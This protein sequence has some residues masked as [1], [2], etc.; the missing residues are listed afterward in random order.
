MQTPFE[1]FESKA[2]FIDYFYIGFDIDSL[3]DLVMSQDEMQEIVD[4]FND[5]IDRGITEGERS[6]FLD[7]LTELIEVISESDS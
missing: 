4:T 6:D 1:M 5:S 2:D 3:I 7:I